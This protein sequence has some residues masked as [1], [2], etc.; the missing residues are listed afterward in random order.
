[1]L[2]KYGK[3]SRELLERFYFSFLHCEGVFD[4]TIIPFALVECEMNINLS[5]LSVEFW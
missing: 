5:N 2:Y 3:C 1:M 4:K